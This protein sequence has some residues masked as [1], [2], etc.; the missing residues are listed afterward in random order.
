M[1]FYISNQILAV[2]VIRNISLLSGFKNE[3]KSG[4]SF[5]PKFSLQVTRSC[6]G[7]FLSN[8]NKDFFIYLKGSDITLIG[9]KNHQSYIQIVNWYLCYLQRTLRNYALCVKCVKFG[10]K[11]T[12]FEQFFSKYMYVDMVDINAFWKKYV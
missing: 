4:S 8:I 11:S 7:F 3:C 1:T 12:H 6:W 10:L 5:H 2:L 9:M